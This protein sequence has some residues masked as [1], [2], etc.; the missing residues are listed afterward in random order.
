M[1]VETF[2]GVDVDLDA[3]LSQTEFVALG[4]NGAAFYYAGRLIREGQGLGL[5]LLA[6]VDRM[7]ATLAK[8]GGRLSAD[9]VDYV[10]RRLGLPRVPPLGQ[11]SL[12]G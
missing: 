11:L 5:D 8:H 7:Q 4:L 3:H 6:N 2:A 9:H 12:L 1:T 10:L